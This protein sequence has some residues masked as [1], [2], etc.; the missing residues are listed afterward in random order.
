MLC[1]RVIRLAELDAR[2]C[3]AHEVLSEIPARPAVPRHDERRAL[4]NSG[5]IS[6]SVSATW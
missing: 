6:A 2:G 3:P 1:E 4:Q 5:S